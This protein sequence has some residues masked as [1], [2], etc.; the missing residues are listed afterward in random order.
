MAN[1]NEL[2]GIFFIDTFF[3]LAL[4]GHF[5]LS[6]GVLLV[7]FDFH[8]SGVCVYFFGV[9]FVVFMSFFQREREH[10]IGR[11]VGRT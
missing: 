4:F 10:K 9:L 8:C 6:F 2:N 7:Y 5:S 11:E 3:N 1:K